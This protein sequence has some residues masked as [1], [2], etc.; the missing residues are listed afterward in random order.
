M[1]SCV[2]LEQIRNVTPMTPNGCE[3][4]LKTGTRWIHLRLCMSCGHVGCCDNSVGKHARKHYDST[5]HPI[6]KSF[7][8]G[9]EWKW[10]YVD[11]L[12]MD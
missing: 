8:P 7:E 4:C 11:E 2:H 1:P 9:E 5:R 10:C 3:E 12:Q 6:M